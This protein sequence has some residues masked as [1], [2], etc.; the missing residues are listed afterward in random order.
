M[1]SDTGSTPVWS[2]KSAKWQKCHFAGFLYSRRESNGEAE[3]RSD[4][5]RRRW[6]VRAEAWPETGLKVHPCTFKQTYDIHV[7]GGWA[8]GGTPVWSTVIVFFF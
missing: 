3:E 8:A 5:R 1:I 7:L 6:R 4:E 2:I